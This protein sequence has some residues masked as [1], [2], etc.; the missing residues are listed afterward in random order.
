M[1]KFNKNEM[2]IKKVETTKETK[3]DNI[4][5]LKVKEVERTEIE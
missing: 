5:G 1:D 2:N 4:K 3:V